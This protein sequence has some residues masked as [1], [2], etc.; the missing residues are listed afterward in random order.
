MARLL[1]VLSHSTDDPRRA[2]VGLEAASAAAQGGHEVAVWLMDEGVRLAVPGVSDALLEA[3][4][5]LASESLALLRQHGA[6]LHVSHPCFRARGFAA[7]QLAEGAGLAE[8]AAL[9]DLVADGWVP[10]PG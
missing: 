2:A 10:V 5:R 6:A 7:T 4:P 1:Y 3:G 9:A 8:P